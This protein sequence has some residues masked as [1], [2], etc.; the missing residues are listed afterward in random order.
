[1]EE[2]RIEYLFDD[3]IFMIARL[4]VINYGHEKER[5]FNAYV[6]FKFK[7]NINLNIIYQ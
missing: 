6:Q 7:V 1:M 5:I 4:R 3:Y 2:Q